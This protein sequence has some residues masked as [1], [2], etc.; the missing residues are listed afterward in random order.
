MEPFHRQALSALDSDITGVLHTTAELRH[1]LGERSLVERYLQVEAALAAVQAEVGLIPENA[2]VA[3]GKVTVDDLDFA[4]LAHKMAIVGYPVVG[5]VEQIVDVV[6]DGLGQYAHW[7]ATTQDIMDTGLVLQVKAAFEVITLDLVKLVRA[8]STLADDHRLTPV[9]GRSQ[10]QQ[11]VP[12]TFGYRVAG[13]LSPILRHIERLKELRPRVEVVQFGGAVGTLASIAPN[14][15]EVRD[16]LSDRLSLGDPNISWHSG[17]D[18]IVEIVSWT[19]QLSSSIAKIGHDVALSAQT[20][21]GE[22]AEARV[23]G[24]GTSSTMPQKRNP[25]LAQQLM[26]SGRLTRSYLDL[27]IDGAMADHDRATAA[28]ALEWNSVAPAI[29]VAGGAV[30]A[31][32]RLIGGLEVNTKAM[33]KNLNETG[34]GI[35]AEAVMMKMANELGRQAAHD[36]VAELVQEAASE[37]MTFAEVVE[38]RAPGAIS[39]LDPLNYL[40]H[41][42]EQIDEVLDEAAR[43]I[44]MATAGVEP[45]DGS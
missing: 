13:W 35:M 4:V 23:A 29:A 8:L 42:S 26:R 40:G 32:C 45:R 30:D 18:R 34:G 15:L 22:L 9:A 11:A 44:E 2:A 31:A 24:G 6:P 14:G 3:I 41:A 38:L 33:T 10:M 25:I 39:A 43:I 21:L 36:K 7:G 12:I 19:A 28:W 5:L 37:G 1:I 16:K 27:A 17:R 20:E